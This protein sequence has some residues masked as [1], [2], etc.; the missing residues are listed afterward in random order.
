MQAARDANIVDEPAG[1]GDETRIFA[2]AHG[3]GVFGHGPYSPGPP[4][5]AGST[6]WFSTAIGTRQFSG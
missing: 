6:N 1:S 4:A 5:S 3:P 2:P